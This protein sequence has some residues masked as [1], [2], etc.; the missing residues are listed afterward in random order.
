MSILNHKAKQTYRGLP[1]PLRAAVT[2]PETRNA[3]TAS[4]HDGGNS[5]VIGSMMTVLF[6]NKA[7]QPGF[8]GGVPLTVICGLTFHKTAACKK[9]V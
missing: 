6:S 2:V 4:G 8:Q 3:H 5:E 9:Q 7:S 1:A